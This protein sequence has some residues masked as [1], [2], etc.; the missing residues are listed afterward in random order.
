MRF[1]YKRPYEEATAEKIKLEEKVSK[2]AEETTL[3]NQEIEIQ[4]GT[5]AEQLAEK[6]TALELERSNRKFQEAEANEK[7]LTLEASLSQKQEQLNKMEIKKMAAAYATQETE[8][9]SEVTKWAY[10]VFLAL[11]SLVLA[12]SWSISA[13]QGKIWYERFEFYLVD[14]ICISAVWFSTSQ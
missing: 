8:Y 6:E 11:A 10:N 1:S 5:F 12:F 9:A 2:L 7:I 3:L 13:A 14:I 4:K